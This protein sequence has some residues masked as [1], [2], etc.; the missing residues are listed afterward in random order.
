[1]V[2]QYLGS[3]P[4]L[5]DWQARVKHS[6]GRKEEDHER[7]TKFGLTFNPLF[8]SDN[9]YSSTQNEALAFVPQSTANDICLNAAI[10]I[11]EQVGQYGAKLIGLV[12]DAT[13]V[14]CPEETI[15]V[16]RCEALRRRR[17]S[18]LRELPYQRTVSSRLPASRRNTC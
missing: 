1:M 3:Y 8:V 10:K 18:I 12:H 7:K 15:E 6:V 17:T 2:D 9:N 11:N 13:Y 16:L 4:G 14:E 5:R